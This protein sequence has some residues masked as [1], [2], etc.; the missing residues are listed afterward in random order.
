MY[1]CY[2]PFCVFLQ[3]YGDLKFNLTAYT[4]GILSNITQAL[5]LL[6]VQLCCERKMSTIE[7]LQLNSVNTLPPLIAIAMV[8]QE[9]TG[10]LNYTD[11]FEPV[12]LLVLF[13]VLNM[14]CLLNYSLFLCTSCN[15]AL[16]TSVVG[17]IKALAQTLLGLFTFGGVSINISTFLGIGMNTSGGLLYIYAKFMEGKSKSTGDMEKVASFCTA[18]QFS[19]YKVPDSQENGQIH[20]SKLPPV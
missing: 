12:F 4:C 20:S 14:G 15:C 11:A 7:T 10:V 18:E 2:S 19:E 16:T 6:L 8:K 5:Y 3:G 9:F 13:M 17:G 1:V